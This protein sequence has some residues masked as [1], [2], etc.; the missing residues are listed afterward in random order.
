MSFIRKL[1]KTGSQEHRDIGQRVHSQFRSAKLICTAP[2]SPDLNPIEFFFSVY[3]AML[4]RYSYQKGY[5][6]Q[7][8]HRLALRAMTPEK[9]R[10]FY[11]KAQVP[12]CESLMEEEDDDDCEMVA[13]L[14]AAHVFNKKHSLI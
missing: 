6:W 13:V 5:S 12:N 3:K 9:A 10:H 2:Y 7:T 8:A 4:Q 14:V 11:R 1:F